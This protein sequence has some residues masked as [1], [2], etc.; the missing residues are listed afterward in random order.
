MPGALTMPAGTTVVPLADPARLSDEE[1]LAVR[2]AI[3]AVVAKGPWIGGPRVAAFEADFARFV[4]GGGEVIGCAN[5][6][7]A[8]TLALLALGLPAGGSVLVAANEGGYAATAARQAGLVPVPIDVDPMTMAPTPESAAAGL[9][10]TTCALVVTHLH[11]DPVPI[12]ALDRWRRAHGLALV[13]DCAQAHG[14]REGERHVGTTGDAAAFSFYPTKNLGALGDAGAVMT[15]DAAVA[16]RVRRLA[17]YGWDPRPRIEM[18]GGRN[19]RLD[20]IQAAALSAR[21]PF[22]AARNRRRRDILATYRERA[23]Q[24]DLAGDPVGGVAH[25][26]V[27]RAERRDD[28]AA[29]LERAGIATAVHYG[30]VLGEMRGLDLDGRPEHTPEALRLSRRILSLPCAPELRDD[31]IERVAVALAEWPVS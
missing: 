7:D 2:G 19:S 31:E 21:L 20:P 26:A 24:L 23:P 4:G 5:G 18:P 12:D 17:Q 6:T 15:R 3:E 29:H 9:D 27:V 10:A 11:G 13:E 1:A 8:L 30:F 14:A 16:D 28:L 22:L 25:H